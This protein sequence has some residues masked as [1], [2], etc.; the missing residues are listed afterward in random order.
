MNNCTY[1]ESYKFKSLDKF[2][3]SPYDWDFHWSIEFDAET[4]LPEKGCVKTFE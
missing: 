1:M 3:V 2:S 4:T